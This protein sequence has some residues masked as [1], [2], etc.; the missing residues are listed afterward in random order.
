MS[1]CS[2]FFTGAKVSHDI[3]EDIQVQAA[4]ARAPVK[5]EEHDDI[6]EEIDY[7][8]DFEEADEDDDD[9]YRPS[10]SAAPLP[11]PPDGA[12]KGN[13]VS[14]RPAS[15]QSK[16]VPS[17]E[18]EPA[19]LAD[20]KKALESENERLV[21]RQRAKGGEALTSP[22]KKKGL[23]AEYESTM[24]KFTVS[25]QRAPSSRAAMQRLRDLRKMKVVGK[26][27]EEK[28]DLF[29]LHPQKDINLFLA[30]KSLKYCKLQSVSAQTGDDDMDVGTMTDEV[31]NDE[32]DAQFPTLTMGE[33]GRSDGAQ[34]LP[35]LRR[36]IPLFEASMNERGQSDSAAAGGG[37]D[38]ITGQVRC[39][40]APNFMSQYIDDQASV[41]DV[42]ICPQW[43][44]ADHAL[45]LYTWPE[46]SLP[47]PSVGS[48]LD[49]HMRPLR[50]FIGLYP[51]EGRAGATGGNAP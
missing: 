37:S 26:L 27:S 10:I 35:F 47:P 4:A 40:V 8:D 18:Q 46:V 48:P 19:A 13:L 33:G 6:D 43:Y 30:G 44:G 17:P 2:S 16:R 25:A 15:N 49:S 20:I 5:K 31:W 29:R 51:L 11:A 36:V 14:F 28:I 24:P 45:V 42:A 41:A 3:E 1:S 32:K 38:H 9:E 34:L 21:L 7:D 23:L 22:E 39:C 12:G 50:S